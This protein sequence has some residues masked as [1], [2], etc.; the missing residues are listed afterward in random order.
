MTE[1]FI[2]GKIVKGKRGLSIHLN[3]QHFCCLYDPKRC[4]ICG[5][6][7]KGS[8]KGF[9]NKCRP[10]SGEDNPMFGVSVYSKW[11]KKY[12]EEEAQKK[13]KNYK[14]KATKISKEK[15]K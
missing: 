12:G 10:R 13:L 7:T 6:V 3:R 2:C 5:E 15:W 11:L 8:K 14:E 9:C 4:K 1:C